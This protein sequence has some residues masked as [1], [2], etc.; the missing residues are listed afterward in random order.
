M[1]RK[2]D[3]L[4]DEKQQTSE[5]SGTSPD[6][7]RH[8]SEMN[9]NRDMD[10]NQMDDQDLLIHDTVLPH[11]KRIRKDPSQFVQ[12]QQAAT[13]YPK[14]DVSSISFSQ[15]DLFCSEEKE[16]IFPVIDSYF[17]SLFRLHSFSQQQQEHPCKIVLER[18]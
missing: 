3:L 17:L 8:E 4:N 7:M 12:S 16:E 18:M 5:A 13:S 6:S 1:G 9:S 10:E 11:R 15:F 14:V 2:T